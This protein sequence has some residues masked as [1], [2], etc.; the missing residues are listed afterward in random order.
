MFC[1]LKRQ[2]KI[3]RRLADFVNGLPLSGKLA[4]RPLTFWA[5][6]GPKEQR[7]W[8]VLL[9]IGFLVFL[10]WAHAIQF[11]NGWALISNTSSFLFA[12][13]GAIYSLFNAFAMYAQSA[14]ILRLLI[15]WRRFSHSSVKTIHPRPLTFSFMFLS[16]FITFSGQWLF[17][18]LWQIGRELPFKR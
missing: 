18:Y 14:L 17:S 5:F 3:L 16:I 9:V 1:S 2:I 13:G 10:I 6:S 4:T 12:V 11:M 8:R 15:G 7:W